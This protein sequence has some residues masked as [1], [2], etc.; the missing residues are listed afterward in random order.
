LQLELFLLLARTNMR[1]KM[2]FETMNKIFGKNGGCLLNT[3][4]R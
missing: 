4:L 3:F 1:K 2:Q